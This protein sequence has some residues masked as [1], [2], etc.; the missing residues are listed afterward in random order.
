M[1]CTELTS[2]GSEHFRDYSNKIKCHIKH[3]CM[4]DSA[5]D[6][7]VNIPMVTHMRNIAGSILGYEIYN[8]FIRHFKLQRISG[9]MQEK[10]FIVHLLGYTLQ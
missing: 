3:I 10:S 9:S 5:S 6:F 4:T 2:S 1:I 8:F 7:Y